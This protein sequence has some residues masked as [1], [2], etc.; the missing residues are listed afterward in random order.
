M[1]LQQKR[2]QTPIA[3]L[4]PLLDVIRQPQSTGFT[5]IA[6]GLHQRPCWRRQH[7]PCKDGGR[8]FAE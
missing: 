6:E 7:L 8:T 2:P 5:F 1:Q 3:W 4:H